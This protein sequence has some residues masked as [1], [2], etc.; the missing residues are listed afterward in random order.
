MALVVKEKSQNKEI[1]TRSI[2]NGENNQN[3]SKSD[4]NNIFDK[5][6]KNMQDLKNNLSLIMTREQQTTT[7]SENKTENNSW[8]YFQISVKL[9][10]KLDNLL[11]KKD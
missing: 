8:D 9:K 10:I 6:I 2:E 3:N 4:D 5:I 11:G 7:E 1:I